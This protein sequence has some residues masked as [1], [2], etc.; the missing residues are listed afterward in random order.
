MTAVDHDDVV[1]PVRELI[2]RLLGPQTLGSDPDL[3]VSVDVSRGYDRKGHR[4]T[5]D[6]GAAPGPYSDGDDD[7]VVVEVSV[8]DKSGHGVYPVRGRG[9]FIPG[10]IDGPAVRL[11][12]ELG[13][14]EPLAQAFLGQARAVETEAKRQRLAA[15]TAQQNQTQAQIDALVAEIGPC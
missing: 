10:T 12:V 4:T 3:S 8:E 5:R 15:L 11:R 2:D 14:E 7:T 13:P 9:V 1:A 6:V